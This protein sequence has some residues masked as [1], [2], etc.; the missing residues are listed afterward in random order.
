DPIVKPIG[1]GNQ[2]ERDDVLGDAEVVEHLQSRGMQR[3][4]ALIF[5]RRGLLFEHRDRNAALVER[6]RAHHSNR[7]C[8]DNDDAPPCCHA[9]FAAYFLAAAMSLLTAVQPA[10][11]SAITLAICSG[12][13]P[14]GSTPTLSRRPV[15]SSV[16]T[17]ATIALDTS[18]TI[19]G[20]VPFGARMPL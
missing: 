20:G 9:G 12:V 8:S 10:L 4:C 13:V 5:N 14:E 7:P 1:A 18:F 6:Q 19:S 15:N 2:S 11:S 17:A 16:F 3:G